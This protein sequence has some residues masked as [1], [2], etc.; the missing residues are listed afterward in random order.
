ME[1]ADVA[2]VADA[3]SAAEIADTLRGDPLRV[4]DIPGLGLA[5]VPVPALALPDEITGDHAAEREEVL[6]RM[7]VYLC[8]AL[9]PHVFRF[10]PIRLFS[11]NCRKRIFAFFFFLRPFLEIFVFNSFRLALPLLLPDY[12]V[13]ICS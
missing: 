7:E 1:A 9:L 12:C 13:A 2:V 6:G 11:I 5:T 3:T 8:L 4:G 10:S